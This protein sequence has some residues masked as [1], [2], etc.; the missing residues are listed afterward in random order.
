MRTVGFPRPYFDTGV[1]ESGD[2]TSRPSI[3][4]VVTML[5]FLQF[6]WAGLRR[7]SSHRSRV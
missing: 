5:Q 2:F 7:A 6:G 1:K 4:S 3:L